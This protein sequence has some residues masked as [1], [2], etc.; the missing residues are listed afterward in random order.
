MC[1]EN[2]V[3]EKYNNQFYDF[4]VEHNKKETQLMTEK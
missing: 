3:E 2:N 1:N 4:D